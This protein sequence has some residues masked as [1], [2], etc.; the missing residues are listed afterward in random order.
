MFRFKLRVWTAA[1]D[2]RTV[3]EEEQGSV[4][5]SR[6]RLKI[7]YFKSLSLVHVDPYTGFSSDGSEVNAAKDPGVSFESPEIQT[8][9]PG[10]SG[11]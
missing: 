9:K 7:V 2:R 8:S 1:R 6:R 5:T 10:V 11:P 4:V 3:L